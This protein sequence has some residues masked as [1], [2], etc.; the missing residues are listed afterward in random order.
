ME[1]GSGRSEFTSAVER[2]YEGY[3]TR[4]E[5]GERLDFEAYC[6]QHPGQADELLRLHALMLRLQ[7]ALPGR[8]LFGPGERD[9]S[10][11]TVGPYVLVAELGR[12][13]Q[14]VVYLAQDTRL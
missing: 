2:V 12:G 5:G 4:V 14:S 6:K 9:E 1:S 10:G 8:S 13:G 7:E 11:T 3:L